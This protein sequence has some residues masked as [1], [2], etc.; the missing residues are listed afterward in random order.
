M[1][2]I[3]PSE[4]LCEVTPTANCEQPKRRAAMESL[5]E[6]RRAGGCRRGRRELGESEMGGRCGV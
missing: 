5:R 2:A 3:I 1:A 4:F 6:V